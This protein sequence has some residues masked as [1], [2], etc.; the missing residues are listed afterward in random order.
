MASW[1]HGFMALKGLE[2]HSGRVQCSVASVAGTAV[3]PCSLDC[4][5]VAL[6]FSDVIGSAC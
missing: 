4:L 6:A 5:G 2:A 1:L 3:M